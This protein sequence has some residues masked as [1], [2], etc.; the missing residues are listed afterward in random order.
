MSL[1]DDL[2]IEIA[3]GLRICRVINGVWDSDNNQH[4]V[5]PHKAIGA[6]KKL[7]DTGFTTWEVADSFAHGEGYLRRLR[8]RLLDRPE[9]DSILE[10]QQERERVQ[11]LDAPPQDPALDMQIMARWS[12][13][14]AQ[15]AP[16]M[17][18]SGVGVSLWRLRMYKLDV[19]QLDWS[20]FVDEDGYLEA[21]RA[22][23]Q[24]RY[25]GKI[26]HIA[27]AN[28]SETQ[29]GD[30]LRAGYEI[31]SNQVPYSILDQRA[32]HGLVGLCEE[33]NVALLAN[34]M[35]CGGFLTKRHLGRREPHMKTLKDPRVRN[36]KRLIDVWGGWELFQELLQRLDDLANQYRV[37]IPSIAIRYV[38][39]QPGVAGVVVGARLHVNDHYEANSR[40]FDFE[41]SEDDLARIDAITARANDLQDMARHI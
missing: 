13:L 11:A 37:A 30:A 9:E 21:L 1:P 38:L 14:Q 3:P 7:H 18:Q 15:I 35:L 19:V 2:Y 27:V 39:Q 31:V 28:F 12:P 32:K 36:Y 24:M 25:E 34:G 10:D 41:L 17:V 5:D 33:H 29:L 26:R 6:M 4:R 22:L 23:S 20:P 16:H 8:M 40:L